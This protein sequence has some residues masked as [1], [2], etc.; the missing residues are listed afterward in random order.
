MYACVGTLHAEVAVAEATDS[1]FS[2][3]SPDDAANTMLTMEG[4]INGICAL[5][6]ASSA[7]DGCAAVGEHTIVAV[8]GALECWSVVTCM[9]YTMND[10]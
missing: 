1:K 5:I 8:L 9:R 2:S 10:L 3:G 4:Y 6:Y 7:R